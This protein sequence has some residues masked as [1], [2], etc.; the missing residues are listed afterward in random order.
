MKKFLLILWFLHT[1]FASQSQYYVSGQDRGSIKWKQIKTENFRL[2][3]PSYA[4][5]VAR[6]LAADL[7]Q[8]RRLASSDM[9]HKTKKIDIILHTEASN[10]NGMVVW[11]PKR[12]EL[13]SSYPQDLY[14]QDWFE[15]L[16]LHEYRHVVQIEK[17]NAGITKILSFVIGQQGTGAV[18]GLYVPLWL[19][20]GDA[21]WAETNYSL[22][23]RGRQDVFSAPMRAQFATK[24]IYSFDKATMGSYKDFV[25]GRYVFGY[26]FVN[27]IR[28]DFGDTVWPS[29]LRYVGRNPYMIVPLSHALKKHTGMKKKKLYEYEMQKLDSLWKNVN[30]NRDKP[31]APLFEDGNRLYSSYRF[32]AFVNDSVLFALKTGIDIIPRFITVNINTGKETTVFEPGN[33]EFYNVSFA[34]SVICWSEIRYDLRWAHKRNHVLMSYDLRS[35]KAVRITRQSNYFAPSLNGDASLIVVSE[36]SYESK[37]YLTVIERKT[38]KVIKRFAM[39]DF[40][41]LPSWAGENTIIFLRLHRRGGQAVALLD[42]GSGEVKELTTPDYFTKT[43]PVAFGGKILFTAEYGGVLN[44]YGVP[45]S[46][47]DISRITNYGFPVEN[48]N[49]AGD[50]LLLFSNL[51]AGGYKI[52]SIKADD[53]NAGVYVPAGKVNSR[54]FEVNENLMGADTMKTADFVV[55]NYPKAL[56]LFNIHSWAPLAFDINTYDINPGISV[57]SQNLLGTAVTQAGYKYFT[58]TN[59]HRYY[60]DFTYKG[61]YPELI[62]D[63][64]NERGDVDY[65]DPA[66]YIATGVFAGVAQPLNLTEGKYY[67]FVKPAVYF[68]LKDMKFNEKYI[69]Y[70]FSYLRYRLY[71]HRLL[72]KS[73]RDILPRLGIRGEVNFFHSP[74]GGLVKGNLFAASVRAYFPGIFKHNSLSLYSA[75]Q[76]KNTNYNVYHNIIEGPRGFDYELTSP[77]LLSLK[78][79]YLFPFAYPDYSIGSLIYVKR[80]KINLLC[81]Y[82]DFLG[83][84]NKQDSEN[85]IGEN[86][87]SFGIDVSADAHLLRFQAPFDIGL[88]TV[89]STATNGYTFSLLLK[90]GFDSL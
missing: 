59:G 75:F 28:Q 19:L 25:P 68:G 35:G 7:A 48:L 42:T 33:S 90:A 87:F 15:Q 76:T 63:V 43:R 45:L 18:L 9:L 69:D 86:I 78:A 37:F 44:V 65:N 85:I 84:M 20:E 8:A 51:T 89:Y 4:D 71:A 36:Q 54:L 46:G 77:Q 17:M 74:F 81:D 62:L 34:D 50:S 29:V 47:G 14:P 27:A 16:S 52:S 32:P 22:T 2:V 24:G 11:A 72:K 61:F 57:M 80:L 39:E 79:D 58:G 3:F 10:S 38:G 83:K 12:M 49:P 73:H 13:F 56:H 30:V 41:S 6:D 64:Y 60:V 31:P 70:S 21:V 53:F 88:R 82:V 26:N 23:G 5:S 40:P 55:K 67:N 66:R 1:A